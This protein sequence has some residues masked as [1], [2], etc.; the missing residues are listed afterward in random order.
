[1]QNKITG[2]EQIKFDK[3]DGRIHKREHFHAMEHKSEDM[4]F[5]GRY[6]DFE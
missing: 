1:M 6:S 2:S 3:A 5:S 4:L